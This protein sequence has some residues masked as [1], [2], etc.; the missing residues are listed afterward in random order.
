[1]IGRPAQDALTS[2]CDKPVVSQ[3]ERIA[4]V[5]PAFNEAASIG[6]VIADLPPVGRVVVADNNSTDATAEVARAAGAQ[7]VAARRQGYGSACL[8]GLEHLR[9]LPASQRPSI[10]VF[11]D[12]D[13]SDHP[14]ELG[15]L[16]EPILAGRADLVIG[17]R[18]LRR[19]PRGA[20]LP[21]AIFGNRLA[22]MLMRLF[23]G[24]LY[25]D[26]G[27][28]RA[29]TWDALELLEMRDPDFGWTVEMQ[30]KAA[31]RGL[32]I[33]EVPVR[34]RPRIG[35]SKI[36]GT[37]SGSVRAGCKILWTIFRYGLARR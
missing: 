30:I 32:R 19:Q 14:E 12:A 13:Y 18:M 25:T 37:V 27:P 31:R 23:W 3:A 24:Q 1:M 5:I 6:R 17:S 26:L 29:I 21:Q 28:F 22:C 7:V 15:A 9:N 11:L 16:V 4:V 36:S 8:A 20:L 2:M 35:T 10:V 33:I 34:Y